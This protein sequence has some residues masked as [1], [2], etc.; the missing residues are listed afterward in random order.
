MKKQ[1]FTILCVVILAG[2][3][4]AGTIEATWDTWGGMNEELGEWQDNDTVWVMQA[5][6][7]S[8]DP[9]L[10][11]PTIEGY[12]FT[13]DVDGVDYP[14]AVMPVWHESY[15][16]RDYVIELNADD[17]LYFELD[18]YP[19]GD[20]KELLFTITYYNTGVFA[21]LN[22]VDQSAGSDVVSNRFLAENSYDNGWITETFQIV[23]RPNPT[24]EAVMV[25][26][27]DEFGNPSYPA[28]IDEVTIVTECVPEPA[29]LTM[30]ALGGVMTA[31]RR[32]K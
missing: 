15:Q 17:Q 29:T 12:L 21:K 2:L 10:V 9:Y 31:I 18:N 16:G 19:G 22:P 8:A 11:D 25:S 28:Y 6:S 23:Y 26:F 14:D 4:Q 1:L 3:A 5:D 7:V 13:V 27:V 20:R 30:L 32:R 24:W